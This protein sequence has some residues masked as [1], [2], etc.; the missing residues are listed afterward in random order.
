MP[1]STYDPR[2]RDGRQVD[3]HTD[4][5]SAIEGAQSGQAQTRR[6]LGGC[7]SREGGLDT[8]EGVILK[9]KPTDEESSC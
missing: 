9:L 1:R 3:K 8:P 2:E 6:N 7:T 4:C 5:T